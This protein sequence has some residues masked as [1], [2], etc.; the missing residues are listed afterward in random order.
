MPLPDDTDTE[1][2]F[3]QSPDQVGSIDLL[4]SCNG[5]LLF[6]C[7]E[8]S[9]S[10]HSHGYIV[11][12]PATKQCRTVPSSGWVPPED[13]ERDEEFETTFLFFDPDVPSRFLL[14]QF[15]HD[16]DGALDL[17]GH[18]GGVHIYSSMTGIWSDRSNEWMQFARGGEW[19]DE[20]GV[21]IN[22]CLGSSF[23][24]GMLHFFVKRMH[25][26]DVLIVA[27]DG[28]G[29]I[30]RIMRWPLT[31]YNRAVFIGQSQGLLH[32]IGE[33]FIHEH[34][35]QR[36]RIIMSV[37]VLQDYDAQEWETNKF[38]IW[39]GNLSGGEECRGKDYTVVAFHPDGNLIY[40]VDHKKG[41][42]IQYDVGGNYPE[43][44]QV[45]RLC[46][47][48]HSFDAVTPYVLCF[49]WSSALD[50]NH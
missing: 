23:L 39:G 40:F 19:G 28:E 33:N 15:W 11:C 48:C 10:Y 9:D 24:N 12:N 7:T 2:S 22:S 35:D 30:C 14:I 1:F 38:S 32:C 18:E 47:H 43:N 42:L 34:R 26:K 5:L 36:E 4:C 21:N 37:D 31:I 50:T 17:T 3:T 25:T 45:L 6:G 44:E 29:S 46:N 16:E 41:G 20:Y 27:V 49:S 8:G 13:E